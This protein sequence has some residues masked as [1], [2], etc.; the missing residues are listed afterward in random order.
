MT[1]IHFHT[2]EACCKGVGNEHH[3][4][5]PVYTGILFLYL[6]FDVIQSV[7]F[8]VSIILPAQL[9]WTYGKMWVFIFLDCILEPSACQA[10]YWAIALGCKRCTWCKSSLCFNSSSSQSLH[11]QSE[12]PVLEQRLSS[13]AQGEVL[14][15]KAAAAATTTQK[16]VEFWKAKSEG[17]IKGVRT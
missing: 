6:H 12:K 5:T 9:G 3:K 2:K 15:L 8:K 14:H 11:L 13:H 4:Q 16:L 10:D 7:E 1:Y 17:R